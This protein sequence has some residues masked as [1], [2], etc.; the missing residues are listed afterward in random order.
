M[1]HYAKVIDG[2]VTEVIVAEAEFID[3]LVDSSPSVWIQTSYNTRGNAHY[4]ADNQ[5][6][7]GTPLRGNYAGIGY[8]YD[9]THDVFYAPKPSDNAILNQATWTW[10]VPP[11]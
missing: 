10:E 9:D 1:S 2:K 8:I 11:A 7:N 6:N 3:T 5:P 4:G